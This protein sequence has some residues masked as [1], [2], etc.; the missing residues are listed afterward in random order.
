MWVIGCKPTNTNLNEVHWHKSAKEMSLGASLSAYKGNFLV[1]KLK[2]NHGIASLC[3]A[4]F[5]VQ[6][7]SKIK[8]K[9]IVLQFTKNNKQLGKANNEVEQAI[10]QIDFIE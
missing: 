7:F 4:V 3:Y 9:F 2:W 10:K 5:F 8:V 6:C 1:V